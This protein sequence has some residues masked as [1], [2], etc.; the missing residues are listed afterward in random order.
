MNARDYKRAARALNLSVG[1]LARL[2][3][4]S[5]RHGQKMAAGETPVQEPAA[6][7]IRALLCGWLSPEKVEALK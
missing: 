2:I 5:T 6:I 7:L 3:G 4:Y 1:K